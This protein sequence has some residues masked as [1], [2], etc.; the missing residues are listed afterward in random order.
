MKPTKIFDMMDLAMRARDL[1]LT[2]NPLFVGPPGLGKSEIVQQWCGKEKIPFIDL[3][4]ALLEAPD[5]I[6]FPVVTM[7]AGRQTTVHAT[8]DFWPT[9]GRGVI[10]LDEVNRGTTSVMNCFMQLLTERKVKQYT[11]PQGWVVVVAI[12]PENAEY[13]VNTMD[14]AL[15]DRFEL[16][17]VSYDKSSFSE[18][19]KS[20][21]WDKSVVNFIESNVWQYVRPEELSNVPGAKYLSPRTFSKLNTALKAGINS[22]EDELIIFE[23]VLGRNTGS[24]FFHFRHNESPVL[25]K[26][27]VTDTKNALKKLKK[28]SNPED[29][30]NGYISVTVKD[31][32][33]NDGE[34]TLITDE[35]LID[36]LKIIP[37]DQAPQLVLDLALK[38]GDHKGEIF[39][40]LK[41]D[42][43]LKKLLSTIL[44]H[45]G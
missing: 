24:S 16:F 23:S 42:K 1:G 7:I 22:K 27:L 32:I 40:R 6:G 45:K 18:F 38:R 29:L 37:A 39:E 43:D 44:H 8:P 25:F 9:E 5:L 26:D 31:I 34:P 30:K 4:A 13:D 19:M 28:Y 12:N 41:K 20:N 10:F 2:F 15:R 14:P 11:L 17:E 36:I 3:R 33:E 21:D 35:L